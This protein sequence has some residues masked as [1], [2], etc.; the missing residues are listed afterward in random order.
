M[1]CPKVNS[2][3]QLK[4]LL[5]KSAGKAVTCLISLALVVELQLR[6]ALDQKAVGEYAELDKSGQALDPI[7]VTFCTD[8]GRLVVTDGCHRNAAYRI[9][10][11]SHALARV[12]PG[13]ERT[14]L[15][16]AAGANSK[17]GVKRTTAD[18]RNVIRALLKDREMRSW[19]SNELAR[20][21][22][23]SAP[24]VEDERE[25]LAKERAKAGEPPDAP[26]ARQ[27]RRN[28]KTM[29]VKAPVRDKQPDD[30]ETLVTRTVNQICRLTKDFDAAT[31]LRIVEG[32][33]ARIVGGEA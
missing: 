12:T 29:T 30:P 19:S 20:I 13:D 4:A 33:C 26:V 8:T 15:K 7:A 25:K 16:L 9:N 31:R 6:V 17:H 18:K 32:F 2:I 1:T 21:A 27:C 5:A 22:G 3:E 28:G 24:T 11:R 14:A 10:K 23:V